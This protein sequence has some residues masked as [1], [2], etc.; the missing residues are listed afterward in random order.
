MKT[1]SQNPL[2]GRN[3]REFV[4]RDYNA[5]PPDGLPIWE[6]PKALKLLAKESDSFVR[7]GAGLT[8]WIAGAAGGA[9]LAA[10]VWAGAPVWVRAVALLAAILLLAGA[11]R[12]GRQVW[13]AG[14]QVIDAFCWWTLLPE[15]LPDGG[16]GVEDWRAA[17]V[18]DAVEAR[19][20][21]FG[22]W[23]VV[24]IILSAL[25]FVAPLT[26][27]NSLD[28]GPRFDWYD[29]QSATL[30]VFSVVLVIIGFSSAAVLSWGQFRASRAHAE[31]D[32]IQRWLLRRDR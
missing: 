9:A 10:V 13:Q 2:I 19:V 23:R 27:L 18:S 4:D 20:F 8:A 31:R 11:A 26:F 3:A 30:A 1:S 5:I 14:R 15:R 28:S 21:I 25:S 32:P 7:L 6:R 17:P 12:L 24:R 29:G 22:G 16:V